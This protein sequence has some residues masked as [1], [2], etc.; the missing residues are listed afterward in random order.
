MTTEAMYIT[1][2]MIGDA[3]SVCAQVYYSTIF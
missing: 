3:L 1:A 2:I